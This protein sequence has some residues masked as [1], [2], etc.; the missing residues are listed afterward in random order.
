MPRVSRVLL[1]V[2]L[3]PL[4]I[5]ALS[6]SETASS[7]FERGKKEEAS[8]NY[9]EAY[10]A[11]KVA[12]TLQPSN[13]AYRSS[14]TRLQFLAAAVKV[15]RGIRLRDAGDLKEALLQFEVALQ[16]DPS[17]AIARQQIENTKRAITG[18]Q[19]PNAPD[20][21]G[22]EDALNA[23]LD[24]IEGPIKLAPVA[25]LPITLK[26]SED[27]KVI[28]ETIGRLAG[29]NVLFDPD[30]SSRRIRVELTGINLLQALETLALQSKTFWRPVTPNTIFVAAD[31]PAKR[32]ELEQSVVKTFYLSNLSQPTE[33]QDVVNA[34][35]TVLEV[36]RIQQLPSQQAI[37]MRG[38]PDQILLAEKVVH[39]IDKAPPEVI[40]EVAV[41]QV[42]RDKV[43]NLGINPPSSA[44][45]QLQSN[46]TSSSGSSSSSSNSTSSTSDS[47]SLNSLANL[48]ATDFQVTIGAA[49]LNAL[50]SDSSTKIIQN[51]QLRSI[52]GQKAS[53][54]I[55]E[56]VPTATGSY[57]SGVSSTTVSALVNTQFQYLDVGVNVDITPR[58]FDNGDI[59]MKISL[60]VS[61]VTSYVSIGGISEPEIGQRKIEH[62]IRL[63]DGE[64]NLL[65]GMFETQD[66]KS[67]SG[68][69]GLS[70]IPVLKYLF[71]ETSKETVNN[72]IVFALIPHIVRAR[73]I[74]AL[75]RRTLDVGT[76][77]GIQLHSAE[78]RPAVGGAKGQPA[79]IVPVSVSQLAAAKTSAA[80]DPA[81]VSTRAGA[82]FAVNVMLSNVENASSV[83]LRLVYDP[84]H[85]EVVNVSNGG[86]L[87]QGDQIVALSHREDTSAG[88]L[89]CT[90]LRPRGSG[91]AS[92]NGA[93]IA[94]T[95]LAKSAGLSRLT[96]TD[97]NVVHPDGQMLA[98]P[99]TEMSITV[100]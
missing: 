64:V 33:L 91:G 38:T 86:F 17:S 89:E 68:I 54:K 31:N 3:L 77:N 95:F 48:N 70:N 59:G 25:D 18:A 5:T 60:D 73:E 75:N 35:R 99:A 96:L 65:G 26:L 47:L 29:I 9:E 67:I 44:S 53:L 28:Y 52:N 51:P 37:V 22:G 6:A 27:S 57:S 41:M 81:S 92:G 61:S 80:F 19:T 55:G 49:S 82:T 42:S 15:H 88:V 78:N 63:K 100:Q 10:L 7:A 84:S 69:P 93:A 87:D 56:R 30:Y 76:A 14:A 36:S 11:Y 83:P 8:Q 50:A 43:K 32:K 58:V 97:A 24:A 62:E 45:V 1:V 4:I 98:I 21:N 71:S 85:L 46:T 66:T 74:V 23:E 20:S 40:V 13:I 34:V 16:I 94:V 72:E 90:A 12:Y 39:D 2:L 79:S